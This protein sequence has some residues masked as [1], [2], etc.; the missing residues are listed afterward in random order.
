MA[1]G[2]R[3]GSVAFRVRVVPRI[4]PVRAVVV[5]GAGGGKVDAGWGVVGGRGG[6]GNV[7]CVGLGRG[8]SVPAPVGVAV[9]DVGPA[10]VAAATDALSAAAKSGSAVIPSVRR[11]AIVAR[12]AASVG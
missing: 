1:R 2:V 4:V 7:R 5:G 8:A 3:A 10:A 11:R 6:G 9:P 12:R